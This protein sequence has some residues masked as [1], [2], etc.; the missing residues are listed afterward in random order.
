LIRA[1]GFGYFRLQ[2]HLFRSLPD[3]HFAQNDTNASNQVLE[4]TATR[5]ENYKDEI[6]E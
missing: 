4:R 2:T 6:R 1:G 3:F 5:R